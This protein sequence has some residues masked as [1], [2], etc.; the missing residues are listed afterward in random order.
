MPPARTSSNSACAHST[1]SITKHGVHN[2]RDNVHGHLALILRQ[3]ELQS[4]PPSGTPHTHGPQRRCHLRAD[5]S[6]PC[7]RCPWLGRRMLALVSRATTCAGAPFFVAD[8]NLART[9][10]YLEPTLRANHWPARLFIAHAYPPTFHWPR[11]E[12]IGPAVTCAG[13]ALRQQLRQPSTRKQ[14]SVRTVY[15]PATRVQALALQRRIH[16]DDATF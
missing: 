10:L 14:H 9:A 13:I 4:K 5:Y 11:T 12:F 3:P 16:K 2:P 15:R 7:R 1:R 6:S 8:N